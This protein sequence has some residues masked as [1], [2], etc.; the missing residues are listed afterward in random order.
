MSR[1]GIPQIG[2]FG[3]GRLNPTLQRQPRPFTSVRLMHLG[4]LGLKIPAE[5]YGDTIKWDEIEALRIEWGDYET[6]IY[7]QLK[8]GWSYVWN[9]GRETFTVTDDTGVETIYHNITKLSQLGICWDAFESHQF[10]IILDGSFENTAFL[11]AY[12]YKINNPNP[13]DVEIPPETR[14]AQSIGFS[15]SLVEEYLNR[16]MQLA[17]I[18]LIETSRQ[19]GQESEKAISGEL[20]DKAAILAR[21]TNLDVSAFFPVDLL[22]QEVNKNAS[23][24]NLI[25]QCEKFILGQYIMISLFASINNMSKPVYEPWM[26]WELYKWIGKSSIVITRDRAFDLSPWWG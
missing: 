15:W 19:I 5:Y 22:Q 14:K 11:L 12:I 6:L 10:K 2:W 21:I 18:R 9:L 8:V 1:E 4:H 16:I 26:L 3:I 20:L 24:K 17:Y 13:G 23:S 25:R 7:D